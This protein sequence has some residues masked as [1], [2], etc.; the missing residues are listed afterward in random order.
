MLNTRLS[1]AQAD[2]GNEKTQTEKRN[3]GSQGKRRGAHWLQSS[4]ARDGVSETR[5]QTAKSE[6]LVKSR[7]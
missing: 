5:G 7:P 1:L 2:E 4:K 3:E 6:A